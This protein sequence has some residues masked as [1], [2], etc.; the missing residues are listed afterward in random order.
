MRIDPNL[1][2]PNVQADNVQGTKKNVPQSSELETAQDSAQLGADD[3]VHLSGALGQVQL[4][5][6]KLAQTPDVRAEKVASLRQQVQQGTYKP[7]NEQ[8][9]NAL[10][11]EAFRS[12][13][14]S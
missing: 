8:I 3:T 13:S 4:L 11:S 10:V 9:A 12:G 5:K 14:R 2:Y 7:S 6:A 1:Q